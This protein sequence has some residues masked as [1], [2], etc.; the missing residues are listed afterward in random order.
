MAF[1]QFSV[2]DI[3]D[4]FW[5]FLGHTSAILGPKCFFFFFFGGGKS[6]HHFFSRFGFS[7]VIPES[8]LIFLPVLGHLCQKEKKRGAPE[9]LCPRHSPCVGGQWDEWYTH[10]PNNPV[11]ISID[12]K[13]DRTWFRHFFFIVDAVAGLHRVRGQNDVFFSEAAK[14]IPSTSDFDQ[15]RFKTTF[16][17]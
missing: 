11:L 1:E 16:S 4:N 7:L 13:P 10:M 12:I 3:S 6:V 2:I 15:Y 5:A 9:I 8:I 14:R 17:G